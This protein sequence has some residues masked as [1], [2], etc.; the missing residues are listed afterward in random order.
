MFVIRDFLRL[1][2]LGTPPALSPVNDVHI[3]YDTVTQQPLISKN[4]GPY[5]PFGAT[6]PTGPVGNTGPIGPTGPVGPTGPS[7]PTGPAGSGTP[8]TVAPLPIGYPA[9]IGNPLSGKVS[10]Q[11]HVHEYSKLNTEVYLACDFATFASPSGSSMISGGTTWSVSP[12][13]SATADNNTATELGICLCT[14]DATTT[15]ASG[16]RLGSSGTLVYFR[17]YALADAFDWTWKLAT[18]VAS[19]GTNTFA[20]KAGLIDSITGN[21]AD[22]VWFEWDANSNTHILCKTAVGGVPT[23]AVTTTVVAGTGYHQCRAVKLAGSNTIQFWVDNVNVGSGT[24]ATSA[25][26]AP[27]AYVKKSAGTALIALSLDYFESVMLFAR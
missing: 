11:N 16:I 8:A 10:D 2:G 1:L 12:S 18:K 17:P 3:Y 20:A 26:I 19:D 5:V 23:T 22:G 13:S 6:G 7:G 27:S 14:T 4:T 15:G 21:P 25:F 24:L 9:T